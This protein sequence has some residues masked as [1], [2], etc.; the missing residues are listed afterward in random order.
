MAK[1]ARTTYDKTPYIT[2]G[3]LYEI[4]EDGNLFEVKFDGVDGTHYAGCK[5]CFHLGLE[6]YWEILESKKLSDLDLKVGDKVKLLKKVD[7]GSCIWS[8]GVENIVCNSNYGIP[9]DSVQGISKENWHEL[10]GVWEVE[11]KMET[12]TVHTLNLQVGDVVLWYNKERTVLDVEKI[13]DGA[14]EGEYRLALSDCGIG[15]FDNEELTIVRRVEMHPDD[16]ELTIVRRVEM[17]PDDEELTIVRRVEMHP[18]DEE[19]T[20][21]RRVEMHPDDF[22]KAVSDFAEDNGFKLSNLSFYTQ[23]N[24]YCSVSA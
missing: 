4:K 24:I 20:I 3:K 2:P 21:V 11:R 12:G 15:I 1:F 23:E 18:D 14:W 5:P 10:E 17:H 13:V 6:G 16:E 22:Y 9:G 8:E 7:L 19:P